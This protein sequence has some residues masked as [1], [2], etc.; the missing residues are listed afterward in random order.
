MQQKTQN[1][2]PRLARLMMSPHVGGACAA[3]DEAQQRLLLFRPSPEPR[4][5]VRLPMAALAS[6]QRLT[7]RTDL[8]D[9]HCYVFSRAAL[10]DAL[11]AKPGLAN[12]KQV[13]VLGLWSRS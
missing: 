2:R 3:L 12:I 6:L 9:N 7:V 5:H 8:Q 1:S 4:R 10:R 13:F 11:A